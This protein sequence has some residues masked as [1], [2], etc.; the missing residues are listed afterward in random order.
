MTACGCGC[1]SGVATVTP[2]STYNAPGRPSLRRRVGTHGGFVETML[3]RL[4]SRPTL[5]SLTART[6][7]DMSI[8]LLDGWAVVAD[9]LT[10]YQER[11]ANEG[12]L[13]TATEAVSLFELGRLVGYSPR[14][15]LGASC[16]LAYSLAPEAQALIPAGSQ[17]KNV[18]TDGTPPQTFET[19]E[20]LTARDEWSNLTV[21]R[22]DPAI[23]GGSGDAETVPTLTLEGAN[24][25][26]RP[27]DRILF[28]FGSATPVSRVVASVMPDFVKGLTAVGLVLPATAQS[29]AD[30]AVTALGDALAAAVDTAPGSLQRQPYYPTLTTW[31][32]HPGALLSGELAEE[33]TQVREQVALQRPHATPDVSDWLKRHLDPA[34]EAADRLQATL[35]Q[36]ERAVAPAIYE[37]T[38]AAALALCPDSGPSVDV[39]RRR[40]G[41]C[42][43][44]AALAGLTP[45]LPAL[46]KPPSQPPA[47]AR[48]LPSTT[49]QAFAPDSDVGAKLLSAADPRLTGV[50][51]PAWANAALTPP[52]PVA[53]VQIMRIKARGS[54]AEDSDHD[55]TST[56]QLDS[57]YDG[58]L[59]GTWIIVENAGVDSYLQIKSVA[60]SMSTPASATL[61]AVPVTVLSLTTNAPE[62]SD[63]VVWGAGESVRPIGDPITDPVAGGEIA[64]DRVYEGLTAGR[65]LIVAGERTDIPFTTGVAGVELTMVGGVK[66]RVDPTVPADVVR[67]T[68]ELAT[69]LAYAYRRDTVKVYGN[70]V[71]ATQGEI[72]GSGDAASPGQVFPLRQVDAQHP[73]T[74]LPADNPQGFQQA[75]TVRVNGVSWQETDV[76]SVAA[77]TDH[78]YAVQTQAGGASVRFGDG[79]LGA[80]LPTGLQNVSAQ[81]RVGA[82][83]A[84]NIAAG[85]ITQLA[86]RPLGV[87]DVTN[88]IAA[89]GGSRGDGPDDARV[90]TPL[91]MLALDRLV[92][93]V[94]YENFTRARA[95]IGKASAQRLSDGTRQVVHVTIAGVDDA[96]V[97]PASDL[98]NTLR[99]SLADFGDPPLPITVAVRELVRIVLAAG[100]HVLA[101]Y[102]WDLVEP[103]V[104]AAALDALGFARQDLGQPAFLSTVVAAMQAVP[105]VDYVH[106]DVFSGISADATPLDLIT[107][108]DHLDVVRA[109]VPARLARLLT[110]MYTPGPGETL[111]SVAERHG[112]TLDELVALNPQLTG[113]EV[114]GQPLTVFSAIAPAQ[115][116]VLSDD[117]PE[118]LRL[119]RIP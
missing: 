30:R 28:L 27:A 15:A 88:P 59:P 32:D 113:I 65:W 23:P 116:A 114:N 19:T 11:I 26:V 89:T 60:Q 48:A 36:Q 71:E 73:L 45:L 22:A 2:V 83:S 118:M 29:P 69:P 39:R 81:Y 21:R 25:S 61:P 74:A 67:T 72:L 52:S 95:G 47:N 104:R 4:S 119:R 92:S 37:A 84:G 105:G 64:L 20:D 51:Y 66:Q 90:V 16:Y 42:E 117:V 63:Y 111:S 50:I 46:R 44:G 77:P 58:L 102:S 103:G 85:Q 54:A 13:R 68:L 49:R 5:A 78:D 12:Y 79:A 38:R 8:A 110:T 40:D 35:T 55:P 93:D 80:R 108:A 91:R 76:L 31:R 109:C 56:I 96:P 34:L 97:D 115:L 18:S 57:V 82:G 17:V 33:I 3:A 87:T 107:I 99:A 7:D 75:I 62:G 9:I 1:R 86:S 98:V 41:D 100:V 6:T 106:V 70:V 112:R 94:D 14:P 10:F 53:D 101:D 43:R 24:V